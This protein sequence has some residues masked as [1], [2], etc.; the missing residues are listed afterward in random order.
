MRIL[1]TRFP[2]ESARGGAEHQTLWLARGLQQRG[3]EVRLLG[4]CAPLAA[5]FRDAGLP[6]ED[7]VLGAP[8]V[9]AWLAISFLWR[10]SAMRRRLIAAIGAMQQKPEAIIMLSLTEKILLTPWAASQGIRV[11]WV[12]HDR[13]GRWLRKNPWL[14]AL[15]R[16][17]SQATIVC[18]SELSRRQYLD[19]GF[20]DSRVTAIPNGIPMPEAGAVEP[21]DGFHVGCVARLSPEKG[22]DV[23]MEAIA[24]VPEATLTIVGTG[25]Q[26]GYLRTLAAEDKARTLIERIRIIPRIESLE[27]FYRSL[28]VFVLPSS[29]HDP[30]GLSAAEAMACGTATIV[31]DACGIAGSLKKDEE[32]L[33][34]EAG[35][36]ESLTGCICRLQDETARKKLASAGEAAVKSRLT[37]A[38]MTDA[39]EECL[40]SA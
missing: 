20:D 11:F 9:T 33:V 36:A 22:V 7:L 29:D 8:P 28:D 14:P 17:A 15:K 19:L 5:M 18:V 25:P 12:E 38:A 13:V 21:H 6:Q 4:H 40:R 39:Y 1:F 34:A 10:K 37:L 16:A 30:F 27:P 31:T 35:S 3:H 2:Y 26:E 23:L 32:V 24:S